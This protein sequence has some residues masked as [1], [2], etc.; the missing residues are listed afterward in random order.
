MSGP[1]VKPRGKARIGFY[2]E[3]GGDILSLFVTKFTV[4][5][6]SR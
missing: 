6:Q 1:A 5:W 2:R 3:L 4:L